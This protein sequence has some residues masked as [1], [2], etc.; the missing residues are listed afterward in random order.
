M[1]LVKHKFIRHQ[2]QRNTRTLIIGTFNPNTV[3]NNT[4]FFYGRGR[5]FL[6]KL[7]PLCFEHED[8]KNKALGEKYNFIKKNKID[9]V[10]LIKE[11]NVKPGQEGN[12][13]DN[14]LDKKVTRWHDILQLIKN[15]NSI[16]KVC[17]TRKT[18]FDIPNMKKR[19][20]DIEELCYNRGIKFR[21]LVTPARFY[22]VQKQQ[23]WK[24][25]FRN[26]N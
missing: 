16:N 17:F 12:Y 3:E 20:E 13:S 19:I 14:Y 21:Y 10:D 6:W 25:F 26:D 9:F 8:L 4:E 18:F 1:V 7:L 24:D 2:I 5:N 15:H 22:S 23:E 11:V